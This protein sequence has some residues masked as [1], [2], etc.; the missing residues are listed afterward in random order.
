[1]KH[2]LY[3]TEEIKRMKVADIRVELA[4]YIVA[5]QPRTYLELLTDKLLIA[6]E[7]KSADISQ[8][9]RVFMAAELRV[10]QETGDYRIKDMIQ[11]LRQVDR[12][13]T[14]NKVRT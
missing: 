9:M 8:A 10:A 1:M 4:A 13:V 2:G 12:H 7:H 3:H 11:K 6:I 5:V 14:R